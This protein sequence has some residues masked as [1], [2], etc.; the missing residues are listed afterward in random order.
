MTENELAFVNL[1]RCLKSSGNYIKQ[2]GKKKMKKEESGLI[3]MIIKSYAALRKYMNTKRS[4]I[5]LPEQFLAAIS[6]AKAELFA[7]Y[8]KDKSQNKVEKLKP[9]VKFSGVAKKLDPK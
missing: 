9:T 3:R 8:G 6:S 4:R 2:G 5:K 7:S 1:V